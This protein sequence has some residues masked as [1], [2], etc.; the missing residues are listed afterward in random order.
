MKKLNRLP[1]KS[2]T[3]KELQKR[4]QKVV[5]HDDPVG[6]AIRIWDNRKPN[7]TKADIDIKAVLSA[8]SSGLNRCMYC[9]DSSGTAVEHFWPKSKYPCLAFTWEN[10][11]LVCSECNN[12]KQD[13]FPLDHGR[14]VLIDP[15][16]D[17][18]IEHMFYLPTMGAFTQRDQRGATTIQIL[19]LND[20]VALRR[21]RRNT[22]TKLQLLIEAYD[23]AKAQG[24]G[25]KLEKYKKVMIEEPFGCMLGWL[26]QTSQGPLA[27]HIEPMCMQALTR[28]PEIQQ[29]T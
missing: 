20:R 17:D 9:E 13:H 18:P 16:V 2:T 29:W 27:Y 4:T 3:L 11:L 28:C 24:D 5:S 22:F 8:M 1:L 21:G 25:K 7:K 19:K 12:C 15:C 6:E 10:Y 14:P 26:L 23:K